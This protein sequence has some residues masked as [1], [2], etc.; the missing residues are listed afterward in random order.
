MTAECLPF[1]FF[2]VLILVHAKFLEFEIGKQAHH[3]TNVHGLQ[4]A[5]ILHNRTD[6][7]L[8]VTPFLSRAGTQTE[9]TIAPITWICQRQLLSI[10]KQH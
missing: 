4:C 8:S 10:S 9:A 2:G 5:H 7:G 3:K 6:A 1:H